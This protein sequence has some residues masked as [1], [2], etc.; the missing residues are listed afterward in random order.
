MCSCAH[1][2]SHA[3]RLCPQKLVRRWSSEWNRI[4][5]KEGPKPTDIHWRLKS[6]TQAWFITDITG[7]WVMFCTEGQPLHGQPSLW[8]VFCTERQPWHSE[9]FLW[10]VF[11]TER[12]PWHS[13]PSPWTV[14]C[15]EGQLWHSTIPYSYKHQ[16]STWIITMLRNLFW[17]I[18]TFLYLK[19]QKWKS[20]LVGHT[21]SFIS[22]FTFRK[23]AQDGFQGFWVKYEPLSQKWKNMQ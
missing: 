10:T 11:C 16:S 1:V 4:L 7:V 8:T 13:E 22:T 6:I 23:S 20:V 15:T 3:T 19:S 18:T 9:P 17:T 2:L 12:Q 14:F 21:L 5:G